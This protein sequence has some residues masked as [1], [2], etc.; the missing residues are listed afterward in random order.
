MQIAPFRALRYNPERISFIS[1][2][3]APPY[4]V[5]P[6]ARA[7]ILRESDPHNVIRLILGKGNEGLHADVEYQKAAATLKVWRRDGVLVREERPA[8]Y[9][10]EQTFRV[11]GEERVRHGLL[12]TALLEESASGRLLPH[13]QT[14]EG[15]REDRLRLMQACRAALSPVFGIFHDGLGV[16]DAALR[17]LASGWP[18]YE[19][20]TDEVAYR[21]WRVTDQDDIRRVAEALAKEQ[22][23]IA[24]GHHRYETAVTYRAA[25][26]SPELPPGRA[27]EDYL[28][29]Y[30]VSARDS[31]LAI[32]PTHRL[33]KAP[34]G[35]DRE[36]FLRAASATF[37]VEKEPAMTPESFAA[38]VRGLGPRSMGCYGGP[39]HVYRLT[40]HGLDP[41]QASLPERSAQWRKLP[42]TL[43]HYLLLEPLLGIPAESAEV[44]QRLLFTPDAEQVYWSVEGGRYDLAF[45]MSPTQVSTVEAIARSGERMPPKSTYFYPKIASGLAIYPFDDADCV[46]VP[47]LL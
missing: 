14:R 35:F 47:P 12:C 25:S 24:D 5:I 46:P 6:D 31:G 43:L 22:L 17:A 32:L 8:L 36:R 21:V 38:F 18:L 23:L 13:E 16:A 30:C 20:R 7:Q 9:V 39:G 37:L 10:C 29:L 26:R 33:V 4:D 1:R 34:E 41:L 19:F 42:V 2:V 3:V 44:D 40:D 11:F 28:L 15:P 45:L 27:A